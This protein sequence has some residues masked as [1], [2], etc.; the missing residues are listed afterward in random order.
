MKVQFSEEL[1]FMELVQ[2]INNNEN[3]IFVLDG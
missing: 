3:A 2:E 1:G